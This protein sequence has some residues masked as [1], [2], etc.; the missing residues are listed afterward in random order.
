MMRFKSS[1]LRIDVK[2]NLTTDSII[3]ITQQRNLQLDCGVKLEKCEI[4][5]T[6]FGELN[7]EKSNAILICHALTGDQ[8]CSGISPVTKKPGWWNNLI[9]PGKIV[10]TNFFYVICSNVIGGCQGTT[11]PSSINPKT[12]K[13]YDLSF[14]VITISD[15]VKGQVRL[16]DALGIKKLFAV[17]GGSM[18][19]MQSLEW[20]AS[21][22][23]RVNA[24]IPIATSYR[25]SAQNIAFHEI[26]RQSIMSDPDWQRGKYSNKNVIPKRGLSV[27]RM[28]AH[29]TYLSESALQRKFGR[30]LQK[31]EVLSYA[32]DVD[33]QIESYL[34]HQGFSFVERFDANSYL[35][36][37]KAMDYFDLSNTKGGLFSI[38]K[39]NKIQF[40]FFTFSSD[41][42]FPTFETKTL[43]K[44]LNSCGANVSFVEIE[45]D[46]GHDAFLLKEPEFHEILDGFLYGL[47]KKI[48]V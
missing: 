28:I 36:I 42:L 26:G 14:P 44:A 19:G 29:I 41:W 30:N 3:N 12:R 40:C 22:P 35:Y 10:D 25:H 48:L 43:I 39:K 17:I 34:K 4:A 11:G 1:N 24:I 16:I 20:G 2:K 37:T 9:G 6:T 38:F 27:A 31:G 7:D 15:M 33:F 45:T 46:K 13:R 32:F 23:D 5:Y 21:F 47:R 18:G 8:Y